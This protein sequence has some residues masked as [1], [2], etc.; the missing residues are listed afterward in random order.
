MSEII[1][2]P[3]PGGPN[4]TIPDVGDENWGQSVTSYLVALPLGVPPTSG[5][6]TLTGDLYFGASFGL[7]SEYFKSP[8]INPAS[9]GLVRLA[10]TDAIE[11]RNNANSGNLS[12]AINGSDQLTFNGTPIGNNFPILVSQG[13]TG[14]TAISAYSIVC[15][16]TTTTNPLQTVSGL[17]LSGQ[18]LTSQGPGM[19][20]TW[21]TIAGSGTV[22]SGTAGQLAYYA[23]S[24]NAVSSNANTAISG[25]Q[26]TLTGTGATLTLSGS[27]AGVN[28]GA[29]GA[30][31]SI[32]ITTATS[33][34]RITV[35]NSSDT[36]TFSQGTPSATNF[37]I[38][39]DTNKGVAIHGSNDGSAAATGYV[40]E[41]ITSSIGLTPIGATDVAT[42]MT[43]ITLSAGNWMLTGWGELMY[44][45][46]TVNW[47]QLGV[48]G[49]TVGKNY[50]E[51]L[52]AA[53][54]NGVVSG[55]IPPYNVRPTTTT[56]YNLTCRA[57][58]SVATPNF[59]GT[60]TAWRIS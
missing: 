20:P 48:G 13:G 25:A 32:D 35:S 34:F 8:T 21:T 58:Y 33:D 31:G 46:A 27:G 28:I 12:L 56:V 39:T 44:N 52:G 3:L 18:A 41:V 49:G 5:T 2:F 59:A 4:F 14:D 30:D 29:S 26:L 45:G 43:S 9:A 19:L 15:G 51:G 24:T 36:T 42:T 55:C 7:V 50:N 6:F 22:N 57:D 54:T 40:G 11:W 23:T 38:Y 17:G 37:L 60:I 10:K 47:V 1:T 53:G 16:G